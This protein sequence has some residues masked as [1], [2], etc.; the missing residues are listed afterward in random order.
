MAN[1][2]KY[3]PTGPDFSNKVT[4]PF[5]SVGTDG[6][7]QGSVGA[8]EIISPNHVRITDV[9]SN[10]RQTHLIQNLIP[11][12]EYT[13]SVQY[14]KLTGTPTFRFQIQG[15]DGGTFKRTI[16]FTNTHETGLA[17][18]DG[19]QTASWTFSL[20]SNENAVRIWW[21]DG[22]DYTTY[23]H[24]FELKNPTL[25]RSYADSSVQIG[26]WTVGHQGHGMGPT[27][28]SEFRNGAQIPSGGF[29]IYSE[30][31]RVRTATNQEELVDILN[32]MGASLQSN[33]ISAALD[34][35][36][37][38][39]ILIL[40]ETFENFVNDG[41]VLNLDARQVSSFVGNKPTVNVVSNTN[42]DTGWSKGYQ[43]YIRWNEIA[44]PTG[45]NSPVVGFNRGTSSA[46]W[47]SYGNYAPQVPG[48]VYTVSLY[49]KT[50]DPS[51]SINYYTAD[52]SET[53][54]VWGPHI[55]VPND[56]KWHRVVWPAF[57]NPTNSQ[58]DSLSF[59][60]SISGPINNDS[61]R[62]WLCAP[63]MELG[64]EATPF[65]AGTR[66]ENTTWNDLS[67]NGNNA[68]LVNGP[69]VQNR[70][71][72]NDGILMDGSDDYGVLDSFTGKPTQYIT[73]EALIKP[74]KGTVSG[75]I[76]GGAISASNS[77]YLGIIN[78]VDG[79]THAMHWANQTTNNRAYNWNG[80]VPDNRWSHIVGTYDGATARA[81]VNGVEISS[82][83]Q[84]GNVSD[85]TYYVGTYGGTVVDG[86]HNLNGKLATSRIYNKSLSAAEVSQ[87][88]FGGPIV[89]D[90]LTYMWDAGNLVSYE[91]GSTITY[92]LGASSRYGTLTNGVAPSSG[93]WTFDGSDDSIILEGSTDSFKLN[94]GQ[95]WTVNAWIRTTSM[96][97]GTAEN[98]I[99]SNSN[100]GPVWSALITYGGKIA[101]THYNNEWIVTA[102][103]GPANVSDGKWH[104]L[105]WV[106][107]GN[108][109][110]NLYVDGVL[111][112]ANV[113]ARL[114]NVNAIDAIGRSWYSSFAGDI[115]NVQI[116]Y[117]S[118][119]SNQVLQNYNAQA[120][121][122]K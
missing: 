70:F 43:S 107:L 106:N 104:Q 51:F 94:Q 42:L 35:A 101:Y 92:N 65:V 26:N 10:T 102:S 57:T 17:D 9:N 100:G 23:T 30:N 59:N 49:V 98:A 38:N 72:H 90:G 4:I 24:S 75:T 115:A 11:G 119:S 13:V 41:L 79:T 85:G 82:W 93:Y 118:M 37:A 34:W 16:K 31:A 60:M 110:M 18:I 97:T 113:D 3:D 50:N 87:N 2:I 6:S 21:Q 121:R 116:N 5:S 33:D 81:Y 84:T 12:K 61:T 27:T 14:L 32:H 112:S 95:N 58:S 8:R 111:D 88:Y 1:R 105:T 54:R 62:T 86:T 52:N 36:K 83:A 44:P 25:K 89:T 56:G 63:Q 47:Y 74:T 64:T 7:G 73:C 77:M 40:S 45:V 96:R 122:F 55:G 19:W 68:R 80:S 117:V 46:Y 22:A 66:S 108:G 109:Y 20:A 120:S 53:G 29:A 28:T 103:T 48:A 114:S 76:R 39:D 91:Q 78:S 71:T 69:T 67:G 15:Y 99:L